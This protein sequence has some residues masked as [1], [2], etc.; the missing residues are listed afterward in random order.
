MKRL[1]V[2]LAGWALSG[3][4][5]IVDTADSREAAL[6][7]V[8]SSHQPGDRHAV[9][10]PIR[11]ESG[12]R[13][14]RLTSVNGGIHLAES[15]R[16]TALRSVN[17]GIRTEAGVRVDELQL[18]NGRLRAGPHLR[19]RGAVQL[20]NGGAELARGTHIDGTLT[21]V[22]ARVE[23]EQTRVGGR[24]VSRN[25]DLST[26]NGSHLQ[27][28]IH[29]QPVSRQDR[30]RN[31]PVITIG[32]GSRV[33]GPMQFDRPVKLR[34]HRSARIGSVHGATVEWFGEAADTG[35]SA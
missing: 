12:S 11:T 8:L 4:V 23:M 17:G 7:S 16:A 26:G 15:T 3:C 14:G 25:G 1:G 31:T 2:L 6:S 19:V 18:V 34:V 30:E 33:D 29:Y 21:S 24:F 13:H 32:P 35:A 9:N 10:Q 22:N 20:T 28:G 27:A 5:V